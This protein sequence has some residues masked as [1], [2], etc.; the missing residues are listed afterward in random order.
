MT[1]KL[2][3]LRVIPHGE[4]DLVIHGLNP[5]GAKVVYYARGAVKSR[6]R[7][8]GGILQPTHYIQVHFRQSHHNPEAMLQMQEAS[9]IEDFDGLRHDY[10]R[11]D[12]ALHFVAL[13]DR[14]SKEGM[15]HSEGVFHLLGNALR[16][17]ETT[18]QL[19]QL[20]LHFELKLLALQGD[21]P[22]IE[23]ADELLQASVKDHERVPVAPDV[24][25]DIKSAV[26]EILHHY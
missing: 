24:F 13:V 23:G 6:K 11:L 2:I 7:F 22:F 17:L 26:A 18:T 21:L 1:E 25:R 8:G 4:S 16:S 9:L 14:M 10:E 19:A 3:V 5:Q 12:L 20:K 15:V